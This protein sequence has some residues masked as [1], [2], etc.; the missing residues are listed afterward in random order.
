[1]QQRVARNR[2]AEPLS[3]SSVL[4]P[5]RRQ[6]R[7]GRQRRR[8]VKGIHVLQQDSPDFQNRQ[9]VPVDGQVVGLDDDL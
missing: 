2:L 1:M 3:L 6:G 8:P 9:R 7:P 4:S 5:H